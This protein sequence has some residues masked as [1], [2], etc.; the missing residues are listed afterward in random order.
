VFV[1]GKPFQ[2]SLLFVNKAAAY[3]SETPFVYSN[4]G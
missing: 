1:P 3:T 4:L 2:H